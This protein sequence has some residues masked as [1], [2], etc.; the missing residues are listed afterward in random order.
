[1]SPVPLAFAFFV[2]HVDAIAHMCRTAAYVLFLVQAFDLLLDLIGHPGVDP[3][4]WVL[5]ALFQL[6]HELVLFGPAGLLVD[7]FPY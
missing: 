1:M 3:I 4:G 5:I 2:V 7:L 6:F